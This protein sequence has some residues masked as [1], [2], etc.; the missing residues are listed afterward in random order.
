MYSSLSSPIS[1]FWKALHVVSITHLYIGFPLTNS[2]HF[3]TPSPRTNPSINYCI[4]VFSWGSPNFHNT[5]PSIHTSKTDKTYLMVTEVRTVIAYLRVRY[6]WNKATP[7]SF[8]FFLSGYR[9]HLLI[10]MCVY[11]I[12]YH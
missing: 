6:D 11:T 2:P 8:D 3:I 10:C 4:Q 1:Q 5:I 9:L 12:K 7:A